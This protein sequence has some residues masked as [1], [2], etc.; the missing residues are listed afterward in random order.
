LIAATPLPYRFTVDLALPC[1]PWRYCFEALALAF[2]EK[3]PPANLPPDELEQRRAE[4]LARLQK[5][6]AERAARLEAALADLA[7]GRWPD[8]LW[9]DFDLHDIS[10]PPNPVVVQPDPAAQGYGWDGP[11]PSVG[12]GAGSEVDAARPQRASIGWS[13]SDTAGRVFV[14]ALEGGGPP[15]GSLQVYEWVACREWTQARQ[16]DYVRR[17]R[18][19]IDE[20]RPAH[21]IYSLRM[22]RQASGA[23]APSAN[24][25]ATGAS[26]ASP[27]GAGG[28]ACGGQIGLRQI[29][30]GFGIGVRS[31]IC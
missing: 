10:L 7:S 18:A 23:G 6:Q 2:K 8:V 30:L 9:D 31:V 16:P 22:K 11:A 24:A 14:L 4:F 19:I 29:D 15:G 13:V 26:T 21:T 20:V 25:S 27:A 5:A 12:Q 3:P 1:V 17:I 28:P